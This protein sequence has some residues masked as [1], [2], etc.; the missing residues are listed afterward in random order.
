MEL[1][2]RR[3]ERRVSDVALLLLSYT[4]AH[5]RRLTASTLS[6]NVTTRTLSNEPGDVTTAAASEYCDNARA[7]DGLVAAL[8]LPREPRPPPVASG[9]SS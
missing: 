2:E 3:V 1:A 5:V 4:H 7:R 6:Q 9:Y 8:Q